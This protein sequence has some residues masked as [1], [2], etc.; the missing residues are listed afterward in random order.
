ME[1]VIHQKYKFV[2]RMIVEGIFFDPEISFLKTILPDLL[3]RKLSDEFQD[4]M[5]DE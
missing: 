4:I 3:S 2:N 5:A 1:N